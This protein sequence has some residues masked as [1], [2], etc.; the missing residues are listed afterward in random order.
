MEKDNG[1][2]AKGKNNRGEVCDYRVEVDGRTIML[3]CNKKK[4]AALLIRNKSHLRRMIID[5]GFGSVQINIDGYDIEGKDK[6]YYE[7][8]MKGKNG[9]ELYKD[10]IKIIHINI[11]KL[12]DKV[13]NKDKLE[14]SK[15]EK[16]CALFLV[17]ERKILEK[18]VK[19]D[20]EFMEL[21]NNIEQITND[22]EIY[23][24]Y[25]KSEL[26]A[27]AEKEEGMEEGF[28]EG[29]KEGRGAKQL[30]IAEYNVPISMDI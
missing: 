30:E 8:E 2:L 23:E 7:Y 26:Y 9:E 29:I 12:K 5:N 18:L 24:E 25:S 17:R 15:F 27:M 1:F 19:D 11:L 10:L 14:L 28:K 16:V 21:K 6:L 20:E 4:S 22:E 3:E 13:Y